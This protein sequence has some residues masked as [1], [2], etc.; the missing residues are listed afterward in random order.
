ME[1]FRFEVQTKT[2][3]ID[4]IIAAKDEESAFRLVDVELEKFFLKKPEMEHVA[5][6]EKKKI[7]K[8]AGFVIHA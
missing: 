7:R 5:L 4:V 1:L 3:V 8:S 6:H 2:K